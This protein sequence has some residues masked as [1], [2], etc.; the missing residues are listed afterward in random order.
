M[1]ITLSRKREV[2]AG[3]IACRAAI[4]REEMARLIDRCWAAAWEE[5]KRI[6]SVDVFVKRK[7]KTPQ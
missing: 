2:A 7:K 5:G 6:S 3:S 4:P 1:G